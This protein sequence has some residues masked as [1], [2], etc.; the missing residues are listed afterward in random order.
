MA[1]VSLLKVTACSAP[2]C[3]IS[4]TN[5]GSILWTLD[6]ALLLRTIRPEAFYKGSSEGTAVWFRQL[7]VNN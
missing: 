2:P 3:P 7:Q 5:A 6:L 1:Q 4:T